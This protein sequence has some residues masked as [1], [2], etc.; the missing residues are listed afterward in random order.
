MKQFGK[1]TEL[2]DELLK[3]Q[4]ETGTLIPNVANG[5]FVR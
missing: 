5:N 4:Q 1:R 3:W 2:P